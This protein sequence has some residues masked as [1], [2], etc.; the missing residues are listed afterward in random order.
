MMNI[1][2]LYK[3]NADPKHPALEF[4]Y[5][6][7]NKI[8]NEADGR[9][10]YRPGIRHPILV[11]KS[12]DLTPATAMDDRIAAVY[13]EPPVSGFFSPLAEKDWHETKRFWLEDKRLAGHICLAEN[14]LIWISAIQAK[15]LTEAAE[16]ETLGILDNTTV[17]HTH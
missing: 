3:Y 11:V 16:E 10:L 14:H 8:L 6:M 5:V 2:K 13:A 12:F 1:G 15:Y 9:R 17:K 7:G 4:L